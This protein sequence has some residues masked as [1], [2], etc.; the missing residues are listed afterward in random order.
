[1]I[2]KDLFEFSMDKGR[3][4][5]QEND[6]GKY[7]YIVKSGILELIIKGER[8]KLF[9]E[10]DCFGELA[11]LQK[12]KRTGTVK[13]VTEVQ[14]F[15]LDGQ[16]FRDLVKSINQNK[17]K[18]KLFFINMIP[19]IRSLE[20]IQK[21]NLARLIN[22]VSF[23]DQDKIICEG[24]VG[25]RM[26]IIKEGIV[27][28]RSKNKE[29]RKLYAKDFFGHN[30]ILIECKRSLDV[31]SIG[32]TTC[33]EFSKNTLIEA[34][35]PTYKETILFSI[36]KECLLRNK[37][38]SEIFNENQFERMFEY[39]ELRIYKNQEV[40]YQ[41]GV[42][43]RKIVILIEGNIINVM[44]CIYFLPFMNLKKYKF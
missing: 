28:C 31:I 25:D 23:E 42:K 5:F 34:I 2:L 7:F 22:L 24:D 1:M 35:G 16:V 9:N 6:D 36:F 43:N 21:T 3:V 40:V 20:N 44:Y 33:Y 13:C 37:F 18:D 41:K 17:L 15:V 27:S 8:K 14:L 32:K 30:S 38:F 12:C 26:Y 29:I 19:M 10:W 39:F 11:L 4:L